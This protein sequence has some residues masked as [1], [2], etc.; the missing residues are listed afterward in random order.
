MQLG[1]LQAIRVQGAKYL[2]IC[3][4]QVSS[5]NYSNK[6]TGDIVQEKLD[7]IKNTVGRK[8]NQNQNAENWILDLEQRTETRWKKILLLIML[9]CRAVR[10]VSFVLEDSCQG[11]R[12]FSGMGSSVGR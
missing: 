11:C 2:L 7:S 9:T 1:Q 3:N 4:L 8:K 10:G 6:I 5:G 12:Y